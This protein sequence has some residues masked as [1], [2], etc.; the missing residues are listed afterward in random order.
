MSAL[1]QLIAYGKQNEELELRHIANDYHTYSTK[2]P[3][4]IIIAR[5]GD[6]VYV[7]FLELS[8]LNQDIVN[9]NDV[10]KLILTMTVGGIKFQQFPISLLIDLHE[11]IMSEGKMYINLC[12]DMFFKDFKIVRLMRGVNVSFQLNQ[13]EIISDYGILTTNTYL[14]SDIRQEMAELCRKELIQQISFVEIKVDLN[15]ETHTSDT[16][17]LCNLPFYSISKGFFIQCDDVN[18]LNNI[19]LAFDECERFNLNRFLIMTKCKK[20]NCNL[21]YL[22]FNFEKKYSEITI[23]SFEGSPNFSHINKI[24]LKLKFNTAI[25]N[26]KVY[27]L[28]SNIFY[29]STGMGGLKYDVDLCNGIY[30]L[31]NNTLGTTNYTVPTIE[32]I[33]NEDK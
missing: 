22:P 10:R 14:D 30:D 25:N 20:I 19:R 18:N 5:D 1:T 29:T 7:D 27:C 9:L 26:V 4:P 8:F 15:D 17:D 16:F 31:R 11:P 32:S 28:H 6:I 12:F 13:N 33:I 21:L 23:E 24:S 2:Y 3:T